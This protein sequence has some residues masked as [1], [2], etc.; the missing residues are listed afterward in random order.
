[1]RGFPRILRGVTVALLAILPAVAAPVIS[2]TVATPSDGNAN[3]HRTKPV[4]VTLSATDDSG[5]AKLQYSLDGGATVVDAPIAPGRSVSA[6][7]QVS[8][9]GNTSLRYCA[10]NTAGNYSVGDAAAPPPPAGGGRGGGG[11]GGGRGAAGASGGRGGGGRGPG[12]P[13]GF[14]RGG[15]TASV[16][17]A[18][19]SAGATGIRLSN[20]DGRTA[21]E[22]LYIGTGSSQELV[23]VARIDATAADPAPNVILTAGLKNDHPVPA[24]NGVFTTYR[25]LAV[26]IDTMGPVAAYPMLNDGKVMQSATLT[27]TLSDPQGSGGSAIWRMEMD[28][29]QVYPHP[30]ELNRYTVG[31]HIQMVTLQDIAGNAVSQTTALQVTTSFADLDTVLD[32]YAKNAWSTTLA[33]DVAAGAK[34]INLA[35]PLGFRAG[36]TLMIGT[37]ANQ[38]TATI[39]LVA[40]PPG[41]GPHVTLAAGL[42]MAHSAGEGT[43]VSNPR[44]LIPVAATTSLRATLKKAADEA[45]AGQKPAAIATLKQF[46]AAVAAQVPAATMAEERAALTSAAQSL[47]DDL[48]GKPVQVSGLG[49]T[50]AAG[51]PMI[52]IFTYPTPPVHNPNAKYKVLVNGQTNGFRHEHVPDTEAMIQKLG[53]EHDFDVDIWDNPSAPGS[54]GLPI[55]KGVTLTTSPF[56]D[57]NALRQ[58]KTL[59]FDSTVGRFPQGSLNE[60]EFANLQAYIRGGGGIVFIHG[61]IDAYQDVPW[62]VDLDGGGFSGHGGNAMGIVPDCMSC[63]EVEVD[64][65]DKSHPAMET[66]QKK[67]PIHDELYN[68]SR[69]PVELDLVH[70]LLLENE[71]TLIGEIN[72]STGPLM[73]SDR[74]G[75]VWC[76]N[77]DGGRSFTSVLGHNWMLAHDAWFQ[78]M[79][80]GGIQTTARVVPAN[81]VTY[82]EV[83]DLLAESTKS[84]GINA[85]GNTALSAPLAKAR[86]EYDNGDAKAA[87]AT[88]S[89]FVTGTVNQSYCK[90][91]SGACADNGAALAKLHAKALELTSWMRGQ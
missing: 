48:N 70:P 17:S 59:V 49:V 79:I 13:G 75:L 36:Q 8:Q 1:M 28:G 40:S 51:T 55:P 43:P 2:A 57:V 88:L 76:R 91:T 44:P 68:T 72:V 9:E 69:N 41:Q 50:T 77:F 89:A 62:Y 4:S 84:G 87:L 46:S 81:C 10:I 32:Q 85:A 64:V 61:G 53:A 22:K 42:K 11:G 33:L 47:I 6:T 37:G 82:V 90:G 5:V 35:Q 21:G 24:Q 56:L 7:I 31:K 26:L 45:T 78:N 34:G 80:L 74:H 38:E 52:R 30:Q 16:L 54:P 18:S 63:G 86:A 12:G 19:A 20:A 67:F 65:V 15:A 73:N 58:Y 83:L 14:G 23:T 29:K 71:S 27:P 3:W 66:L 39:A 60:Q 25:T